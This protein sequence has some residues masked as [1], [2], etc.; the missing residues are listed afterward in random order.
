MGAGGSG[1]DGRRDRREGRGLGSHLTGHPVPRTVCAACRE[2]ANTRKSG[3]RP[4]PI[5]VLPTPRPRPSRGPGTCQVYSPVPRLLRRLRRGPFWDREGCGGQGRGDGGGGG[6]L[7]RWRRAGQEVR[8]AYGEEQVGTCASQA[9]R[10]APGR[11]LSSTCNLAHP[12]LSMPS[13]SPTTSHCCPGQLQEGK[14][15]PMSPWCKAFQYLSPAL[16]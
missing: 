5:N 11:P 6:L 13:L 2:T 16:N 12:Q 3:M 1:G 10:A 4:L 8:P 7:K 14:Y 15:A 9:P